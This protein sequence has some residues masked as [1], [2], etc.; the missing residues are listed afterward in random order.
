MSEIE[1]PPIR[2][3]QWEPPGPP[4]TSAMEAAIRELK[5]KIDADR[6]KEIEAEVIG[7]L[8]RGVRGEQGIWPDW[9]YEARDAIRH[10]N[11]K[12]PWL[13]DLLKILGWKGGTVH[14]AL[15]AVARLVEA[16]KEENK[17]RCPACGWPAESSGRCMRLGCCNNV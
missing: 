9:V 8:E 6:R 10:Q 14:Q 16:D 15:N 3:G 4:D 2:H 17:P 13:P 5:A 7:R 12:I 11:K 1:R